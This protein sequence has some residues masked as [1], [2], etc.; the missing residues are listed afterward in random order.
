MV[1]CHNLCA[2]VHNYHETRCG[3][4]NKGVESLK[5]RCGKYILHTFSAHFIEKW[6]FDLRL[7]YFFVR[8][9][10][11]KVFS[12]AFLS[13]FCTFAPEND[14]RRITVRSHVADVGADL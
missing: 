13:F 14:I 1:V 2:K 4:C 7:S 11:K 9:R 12:F 10:K 5:F 8:K 3:K 6:Y